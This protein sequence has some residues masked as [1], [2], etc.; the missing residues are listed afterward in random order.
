MRDVKILGVLER[1][2]DRAPDV[3]LLL[4]K[5]RGRQ[6][7]RIG[8]DRIAEQDELHQRDHDDHRK[9]HAVAL[10][11]N[12]LLEQHRPGSPPES[13]VCGAFAHLKLSCALARRSMNTSSSEA[14]DRFQVRL[15]FSR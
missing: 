7:A 9:G 10:E 14:L 13:S 12:E 3:A 8:V 11:L 4:E 6:V 1:M 2:Q 15:A 5:N